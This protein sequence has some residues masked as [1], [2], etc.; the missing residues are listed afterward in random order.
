[1]KLDGRLAKRL[2]MVEA[3]VGNTPLF[4]IH[5][6]YHGEDRVICAKAEHLNLTGS[7]KDRMAL[8][9]LRRPTR[10]TIKPGDPIAEAT[11]GNTGIS[12][13]AIGRA[14]GHPVTIFMPDWMSR[15]SVLLIQSL[16][17]TIVPV[18]H[19]QGGFLGS[20]RM[21]EESRHEPGQC[22]S[23]PPV[24]QRG[25][26]GSPPAD[27]RTGDHLPTGG[28]RTNGRRLRRRRGHGRNHHGRG[29]ELR[30]KNHK[31]AFIRW[32]L[33]SRRRFRPAARSA[34]I[35]SRAFPTSSFPPI[36]KLD[37]WIA[38]YRSTTAMPS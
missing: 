36:I 25:K 4:E 14:L 38:S 9:I 34:T 35:V 3:L 23:P 20:I 30:E 17:A 13:A 7:I 15:E 22:L 27:N 8:H 21:A 12:L 1:M 19:E 26:R 37:N 16:G 5:Y 11:S 29:P 31:S 32:N 24:L 2:Q 33:P 10:G 6:R 18:S 28:L